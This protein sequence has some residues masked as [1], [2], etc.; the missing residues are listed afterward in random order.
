MTQRPIAPCLWFDTQAEE[1]VDFY[2]SIFPDSRTVHVDRFSNAGPDG[3]A[4]VVV[5]EF[6][7]NGQPFQALNGGPIFQHSPAISFFV[8]CPAD[9]VDR[10]WAAL[11]DGGMALMPLDAYPFAE[12]YGWVQDRYGLSWQL[13]ATDA[14]L[15]I[16]PKL[17][18]VGDN[19]GRVEEALGF[20]TSVFKDARIESIDRYGPGTPE[21]EDAI[22]HARFTLEG[23]PF[24][25]M[26]SSLDHAWGFT[27]ALSL[28]IG[29]ED[30]Q[31]VDYY[32]DALISGGGEP[33]QCG[34]LK[35]RYG[36]SWQVVPRVLLDL[37]RDPDQKR[38]SQAMRRM[39]QMGKLDIAELQAAFDA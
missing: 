3:D 13:M 25:A 28:S 6:E 10:L 2:T 35:D 18:F 27:E 9:E 16:T 24:M 33:S 8:T 14:P 4:Q 17:T 5:I 7:L 19:F 31:Q 11:I 22:S 1:A 30:Q 38:A 15:A 34:W 21:R 26:E 37:L 29:C 20:Y 23:K 32:W 12:K 36:V 39:L